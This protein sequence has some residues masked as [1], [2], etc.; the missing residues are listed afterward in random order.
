VP[1]DSKPNDPLDET[2]LDTYL[3]EKL[4]FTANFSNTATDE[5]EVI[6]FELDGNVIRRMLL[7][8]ILALWGME[9]RKGKM[10][11]FFS[12]VDQHNRI[13]VS[14][15]GLWYHCVRAVEKSMSE[16]QGSTA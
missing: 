15:K 16:A 8:A 2:Y 5:I 13:L 6:L 10:L 1:A 9:K 4:I 7:D 12:C 11:E 3:G 14:K